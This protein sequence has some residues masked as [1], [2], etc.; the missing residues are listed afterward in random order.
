MTKDDKTQGRVSEQVYRDLPEGHRTT[1]VVGMSDML[2]RMSQ[3]LDAQSI[4]AFEPLLDTARQ[5]DSGGLRELFDHYLTGASADKKSG[6]ASSFLAML[7]K[8][9]GALR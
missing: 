6:V 9:S 3:Y 4:K 5:Y 1:F 8:E 7:I 2:E